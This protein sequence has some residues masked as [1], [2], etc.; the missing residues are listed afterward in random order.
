[1]ADESFHAL[2]ERLIVQGY[3]QGKTH[4]LS[5]LASPGYV[6]HALPEGFPP[7]L[8]GT[9]GFIGVVREAMPDLSYTVEDS[10]LAAD[11][12]AVRVL[13]RGTMRGH[14]LGHA[15]TGREATWPE[16]HVWAVDQ[17]RLIEHWSIID[18]LGMFKQL[19]LMPGV[20]SIEI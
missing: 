7:S 20:R 18:W 14:L 4:V 3:G 16:I 1:M 12:L 15:A 8:E 10:F 13:G 6:D 17:G 9:K 19:G 5:D 11:R 2:A